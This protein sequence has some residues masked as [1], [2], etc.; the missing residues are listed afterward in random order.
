MSLRDHDIFLEKKWLRL[1]FDSLRLV[2]FKVFLIATEIET[3]KMRHLQG[4]LVGYEVQKG[5]NR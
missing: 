3:L 4:M 2:F 5:R 1:D